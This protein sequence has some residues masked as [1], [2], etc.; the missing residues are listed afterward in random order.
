[1]NNVTLWGAPWCSPCKQIKPKLV[2][3]CKDSGYPFQYR[4][5][6]AEPAAAV[7]RGITA[8]PTIEVG[9]G[10]FHATNMPWSKI[11]D[12]VSRLMTE[13]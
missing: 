10:T 8:V 6:D 2:K 1:M 4:D 9:E 7:N 13:A 12:T 11:K 3:F 5:I